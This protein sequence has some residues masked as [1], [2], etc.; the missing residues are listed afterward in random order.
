MI[1]YHAKKTFSTRKFADYIHV[2]FEGDGGVERKDK[3]LLSEL[4]DN[5]NAVKF[6]ILS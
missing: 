3:I 5:N 4:K 1:R 2:G 6:R